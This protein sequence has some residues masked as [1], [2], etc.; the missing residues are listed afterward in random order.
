MTILLI[1]SVL[2][3]IALYYQANLQFNQMGFQWK[4]IILN[5]ISLRVRNG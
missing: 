1:V 2:L 4:V 3:A 5:I